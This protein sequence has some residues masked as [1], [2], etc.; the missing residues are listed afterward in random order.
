[1]KNFLQASLIILS[2]V[3]ITS[4]SSD[5]EDPTHE[6]GTW[7]LENFIISELPSTYSRSEGIVRS[8]AYYGY[9]TYK[10]ELNSDKTFLISIKFLGNPTSTGTGVWELTEEQLKLTI[11]EGEDEVSIEYNV[12]QNESNQLWISENIDPNNIDVF[13]SDAIQDELIADYDG[14]D[15]ANAYIQGLDSS[16]PDD[17]AEL[18]RIFT[19]PTFDL[20]YAFIKSE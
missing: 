3:F 6:M 7:V 18:N 11:G 19:S 14:V 9:E 4:C 17:L 10:L 2:F 20:V 16:D 1:M 13:I 5:D 15:G 8:L 12:I